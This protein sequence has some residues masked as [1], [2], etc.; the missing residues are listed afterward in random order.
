LFLCAKVGSVTATKRQLAQWA[1]LKIRKDRDEAGLF[2]AEGR[3][4]AAE[5]DT[6]GWAIEAL[7]VLEGASEADEA[8]S[9]TEEQ[10]S[11]VSGFR[12]A[13]EV[14]AVVRKPL[15]LEP[16]R[17]VPGTLAL[18]LDGV[19][20]PG[21]VGTLIRTA[22]W[23]G[24]AAVFH[25]AETADPFGPKAVQASMG[26][27]LRVKTG[28]VDSTW[29][30]SLPSETPVVG[31]F[32]TGE[33]L[34]GAALPQSGLLVM[35]NE[36][37]GIDVLASVVKRRLTIPPTTSGIESLNVAA[38]AAIVMAEFRRGGL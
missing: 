21:N 2:L 12:T 14:I 10:M 38:A 9:L 5:V 6:A 35:G 36:G 8:Y 34:F 33:P 37:H 11:R 16:P 32:L 22:A 25:T 7:L 24:F 15:S 1:A 13:P 18:V 17:W 31:A 4:L 28:I 3:K 29:F 20:D 27:L 26:A 19:Q 23:F 30:Q